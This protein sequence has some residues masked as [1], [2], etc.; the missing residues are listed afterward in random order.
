MMRECLCAAVVIIASPTRQV[1]EY[2]D[3]DTT[4]I[5]NPGRESEKMHESMEDQNLNSRIL[6]S[7]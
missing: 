1:R 3:G 7:K 2:L 5:S 4:F 6:L